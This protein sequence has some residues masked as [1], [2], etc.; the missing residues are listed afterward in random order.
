MNWPNY[1]K[2]LI[3]ERNAAYFFVGQILK[4]AGPLREFV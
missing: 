3:C 2:K 4:I 1:A